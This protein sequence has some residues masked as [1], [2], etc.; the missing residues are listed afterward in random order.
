MSPLSNK[1]KKLLE[2]LK[3]IFETVGA[4][5][6]VALPLLK[7]IGVGAASFALA[8]YLGDAKH[9]TSDTEQKKQYAVFEQRR[10]SALALAAANGKKAAEL[11]LVVA[12]KN[13]KINELESQSRVH[14][15]LAQKATASAVL[16]EKKLK[17]TTT[18]LRD[19]VDVFVALLPQ[20]DEIIF[21]QHATIAAKTQ[22]LAELE[23]IAK[24][25]A[26]V[27]QQSKETIDS[28]TAAINAAP[29]PEKPNNKFLG[30]IPKPSRVV[31]FM[32]GVA[33]TALA[34]AAGGR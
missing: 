15:I 21:Q 33:M 27:A 1:T 7:F 20:K 34:V 22:Q 9:T 31:S 29:K 23:D 28:L 25:N 11:E 32:T 12:K 13:Q 5:M 30:F 3:L 6:S 16:L 26:L 17:D 4:L 24:I 2:H 10:D 14:I 18:T 8:T 19:S